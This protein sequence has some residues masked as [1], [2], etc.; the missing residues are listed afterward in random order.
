MIV[1][2]EYK[3][4]IG[5]IVT[6]IVR[7]FE[8]GEISVDLGKAEAAI[9][10]K[11]Q[12]P[13]E[14]YKVGDR[15]QAYFLEINP[16]RSGSMLVLSRKHPNLVKQLFSQEVP[17]I[18]EGIVEIKGCVREAGV[19]AKIA[20]Y[21]K[22]SDVDPVGACVGMKGSR[23][24]SVVQELRGEKID[25]VPWDEDIARFV[26]NAIAPA[27]VSKVII[28]EREKVMEVIVP[29]D[30]LSLAIGRHGQNVRLAAQLTGWNIDMLSEAKLEELASRAKAVMGKVLE[31]SDGN[32]ILLYTHGFRNFEDIAKSEWE[33]LK[34]VPGIAEKELQTIKVKAEKAVESGLKTVSVTQEMFKNPIQQAMKKNEE[35]ELEESKEDISEVTQENGE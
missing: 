8:K 29:D 25:I 1:F 5:D 9:P 20:V 18:A 2:E 4:R 6:G 22:D 28:K 26:C 30:Q 12:I 10:R 23:V 32:V 11:E 17:E 13:S 34:Q 3:S 31:T 16:D 24:Q 15:V 27:V 19:R 14:H 35:K 21:S 7:R 33:T